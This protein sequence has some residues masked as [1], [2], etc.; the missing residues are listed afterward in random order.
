M[1]TVYNNMEEHSGIESILDFKY[2]LR[3]YKRSRTKAYVELWGGFLCVS[4]RDKRS[5]WSSGKSGR[6]F[7]YSSDNYDLVFDDIRGHVLLNGDIFQF[8]FHILRVYNMEYSK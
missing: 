6:S 5:V 1:S 2:V 8:I 7:W 3:Y 4:I